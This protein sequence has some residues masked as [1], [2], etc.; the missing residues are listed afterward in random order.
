MHL[1][2]QPVTIDPR[3]FANIAAGNSDV[4]EGSEYKRIRWFRS[5]CARSRFFLHMLHQMRGL[6]DDCCRRR[7]YG[8]GQRRRQVR[9]SSSACAPWCNKMKC[10]LQSRF[11]LSHVAGDGRVVG[12]ATMA[13]SGCSAVP[14]CNKSFNVHNSVAHFRRRWTHGGG[15]RGG[16]QDLA[17]ELCLCSV[18]YTAE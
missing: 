1:H 7:S 2:V 14:C 10:F 15:Q 9:G 13:T 5:T 11:F 17:V 4:V 3:L 12:V 8:G 16:R 6:P 18:I